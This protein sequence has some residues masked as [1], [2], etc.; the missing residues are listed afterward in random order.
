MWKNNM[1]IDH[2]LLKWNCWDNKFYKVKDE[3]LFQED[4]SR[5]SYD[6]KQSAR[7]KRKE[8]KK[9]EVEAMIEWM[10][11]R[12]R[13]IEKGINTFWKIYIY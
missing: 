13:D 9:E 6:F 11:K 4:P 10:K 1:H 7:E 3:Y 5:C 8:L 12:L 2:L